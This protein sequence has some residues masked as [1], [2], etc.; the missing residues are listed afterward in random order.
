MRGRELEVEERMYAC[1][2][3]S[4]KE[5]L[6]IRTKRTNCDVAIWEP[7]D[8]LTKV[9]R[10]GYVYPVEGSTKSP[11]FHTVRQRPR[12][13]P[14]ENGLTHYQPPIATTIFTAD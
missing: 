9:A 14:L 11:C 8:R 2:Y 13:G 12:G 3:A 1:T 6:A 4:K 10:T 7:I 5:T